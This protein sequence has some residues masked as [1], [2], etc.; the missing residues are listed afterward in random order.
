MKLCLDPA[1]GPKAVDSGK[2]AGTGS[3]A[4]TVAKVAGESGH[5][6]QHMWRLKAAFVRLSIMKT[7]ASQDS[8]DP[9]PVQE[10]YR[11]TPRWLRLA[12]ILLTF[13]RV[14]WAGPETLKELEKGAV[15]IV[16]DGDSFRMQGDTVDVRLIGLRA[17]EIA[18]GRRNFIDQPMGEDAHHALEAL[19]RGHTVS[20]R[21]GANDHDRNGRILAYAI[22]DDGLWLETEIL[23]EGWARVYTFPDNRAFAD[24][25]LK[26]EREARAA[27]RGIWG[28]PYY[29]VRGTDPKTL[30][31]DL[32][33]YQIVEGKVVDTAEVR[34]RDYLNF[35]ADYKTDFS[36]AIDKKAMPLFGR[37]RLDPLLLKGKTIRVR[38]F[39]RDY[40]GPI[41]DV[42]HPEQIEVLP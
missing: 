10:F 3:V 21:V 2:I 37:A 25:M 34:G 14:A 12:V 29:A 5:G 18:K 26:A 30:L 8:C 1:V 20:L 11:G 23:R 7:K 24:D 13:P 22:R 9:A 40:N 27:K 36:V 32:N 42:D 17:P 15:A 33:T 39:I 4:E 35:G 31:K 16:K 28:N 6:I 41:I 19:L 38:G